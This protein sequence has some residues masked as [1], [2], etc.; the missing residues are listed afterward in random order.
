MN[1]FFNTGNERSIKAKKNILG[2]FGINGLNIVISLAYVPLILKY[3]DK[4]RYGIW[5]TLAAIV[6]WVGYFDLGMGSGLRNNLVKAFAASDTWLAKKYIS[7]SYALLIMIFGALTLIFFIINPYLNWN[8]LLNSTLINGRELSLLAL[9]VFSMFCLQFI[10]KL[11]TTVLLADQRPALANLFSPI[12]SLLAL[13]MIYILVQTTETGNLVV[14]GIIL[15]VRS[16]FAFTIASIIFYGYGKY[17]IIRPSFK[18]IDFKYTKDILSL[19]LRFFF[20]QITSL[21]LFSSSNFIIAQVLGPEEV[22]PFSI[23]KR[24]FTISIFIFSIIMTP[25]WSAVTDAYQKDDYNWLKNTLKKLNI[26][27]AIFVIMIIGML[28][29]SNWI[30]SIWLGKQLTITYDISLSMALYSIIAIVGTPYSNYINGFGKLKLGT[31]IMIIEIIAFIPLAIF[32]A[33]YTNSPAGVMLATIIINTLGLI[34]EPI[35][36]YKI[37]N[38]KAYG[39]WNK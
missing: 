2:A 27:S 12:A 23:A 11:I 21:V 17:K 25:I 19:G 29:L 1:S 4:E 22:T 38:K 15:S 6:N 33:G 32:L 34:F 39:I 14:L 24:Y 9:I 5:L 20:M 3:L 30:Y 7:T 31:Y 18:F 8:K 26:V 10:L 36:V 37:I 28:F 35:Q 16:V 13:I